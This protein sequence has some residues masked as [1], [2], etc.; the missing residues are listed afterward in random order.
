MFPSTEES[1]SMSV[2][3]PT[4]D[5][6]LSDGRF[7]PRCGSAST[8]TTEP[9]SVVQQ[10]QPAALPV[11]ENLN[12]HLEGLS[13]WLILVGFGLV[14]SPLK[15]VLLI[16]SV[17]IPFLFKTSHQAYFAK[18]HVAAMLVGSEI[19]MNIIFFLSLLFLNYLFFTKKR[20]F[21]TFMII[22]RIVNALLLL[23]NH[24]AFRIF[25]TFRSPQATIAVAASIIGAMI[26]IPYLLFSRRVKATFV[27]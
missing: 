27:R 8:L 15:I 7:C 20:G 6:E 5:A 26:V 3:C 23:S 17:N 21:P 12:S 2:L 4:C 13:G 9:T 11:S 16:F 10:T 1:G 24:I 14:I 22:F 25:T 18:H 19:T